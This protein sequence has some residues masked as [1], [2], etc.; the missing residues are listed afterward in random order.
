MMDKLVKAQDF[1]WAMCQVFIWSCVEP[2]VGIVCACL[3]TFAPFIRRWYETRVTQHSKNTGNDMESK[4]SKR[5]NWSRLRDPSQ[6]RSLDSD[7]E[8][9]AGS[10]KFE[11]DRDGEIMITK[12]FVMRD[13]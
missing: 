2:F 4:G 9:T 1:T 12:D 10:T 7:V 3:P 5:Q 8:L 13:S 11:A 6:N